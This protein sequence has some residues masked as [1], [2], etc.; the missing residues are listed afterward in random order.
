MYETDQSKSLPDEFTSDII[1]IG[2]KYQFSIDMIAEK[3]DENFNIISV[4]FSDT[5]L[6][7]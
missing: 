3:I 6:E 7:K 2:K 5:L 4:K 1:V